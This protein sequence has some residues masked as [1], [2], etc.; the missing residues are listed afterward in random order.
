MHLNSRG[1]EA[2]RGEIYGRCLCLHRAQKYNK[3]DIK[4]N[5]Y[6]V[7]TVQGHPRSSILV[8][9]ESAYATFY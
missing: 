7:L 8:S 5:N 9:I 6:Y 4:I 3:A 2:E 1:I